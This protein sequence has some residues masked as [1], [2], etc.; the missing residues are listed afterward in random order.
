MQ[1]SA[2]AKLGAVT[3]L[4]AEGDLR[5]DCRGLADAGGRPELS[6]RVRVM[7]SCWHRLTLALSS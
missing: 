6:S 4:G 3:K 5:R 2:M 1:P 7:D